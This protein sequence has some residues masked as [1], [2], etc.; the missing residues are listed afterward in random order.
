MTER[1]RRPHAAAG[2]RILSAGVSASLMVAVVGHL[3]ADGRSSASTT[4]TRTNAA[5]LTPLTVAPARPTASAPT[6]TSAGTVAAPP[7][8]RIVTPA[9]PHARSHAS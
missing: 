4:A 1:R 2:A 7:A 6:S 9:T 3:V 5:T 8:P